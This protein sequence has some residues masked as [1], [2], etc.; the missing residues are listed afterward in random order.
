M[1]DA[2]TYLQQH[3]AAATLIDAL[4]EGRACR[5]PTLKWTVMPDGTL[6]AHVPRTGTS[7]NAFRAWAEHLQ[8][9]TEDL[10]RD[11]LT[12]LRAATDRGLP[13][14]GRRVKIVLFAK[15]HARAAQPV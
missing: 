10:S 11:G 4:D 12:V 8:A 1:F 15:F 6:K 9:D 3:E 13:G 5:L 7:R 14:R 2:T